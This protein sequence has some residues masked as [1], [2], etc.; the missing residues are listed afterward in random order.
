MPSST[1]IRAAIVPA[2]PSPPRQWM[3]IEPGRVMKI[4]LAYP[5]L[6]AWV[7][8]STFPVPSG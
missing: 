6:I 2:R 1:S 4:S 3:R 7:A 8:P 5:L